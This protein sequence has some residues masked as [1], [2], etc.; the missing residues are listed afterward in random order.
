MSH[1]YQNCISSTGNEKQVSA[2]YNQS[3][4]LFE[5]LP[6]TRCSVNAIQTNA[7][8]EHLISPP[9]QRRM[10][11]IKIG[12]GGWVAKFVARPQA[13]G[14]HATMETCIMRKICFKQ[15]RAS[16]RIVRSHMSH[17]YQNCISSTGN[18][19]QVSALY[20]QSTLLFES[21]PETRC[22]VN[23]IQTNACAEHLISPNGNWQ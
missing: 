14:P 5:S 23:A 3:T 6:E 11:C 16:T 20:N 12:S 2:L 4:L 9:P 1:I 7:C 8:A 21:L 17:I 22:S 18:E 19:K 13:L 15:M 10:K